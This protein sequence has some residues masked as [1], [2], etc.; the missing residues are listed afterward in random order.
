MFNDQNDTVVSQ[1]RIKLVADSMNKD[2][3]VYAEYR[4][5]GKGIF[6]QKLEHGNS[7]ESG[8]YQM[9]EDI[10]HNPLYIFL[11]KNFGYCKDGVALSKRVETES[12]RYQGI[13][14]LFKEVNDNSPL[15]N[16][17]IETIVRA[18]LDAMPKTMEEH[19]RVYDE[20]LHHRPDTIID[21]LY[22]YDRYK[23]QISANV[24]NPKA[25]NDLE[26]LLY[27]HR[28]LAEK[29]E[30]YRHEANVFGL[31]IYDIEYTTIN[32]QN[33]FTPNYIHDLPLSR[34]TTDYQGTIPEFNKE[35][36]SLLADLRAFAPKHDALFLLLNEIQVFANEKPP[37]ECEHVY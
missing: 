26:Y 28:K 19:Y 36:Q 9:G 30:D 1:K 5:G 35:I 24:T 33:I 20:G 16:G 17:R 18:Y 3:I 10:I 6:G 4:N 34:R 25:L 11:Y 22:G 13:Y 14:T 15:T 8:V 23:E 31:N 21:D 37:K 27:Q 12:D 7:T 29:L 2:N 32:F